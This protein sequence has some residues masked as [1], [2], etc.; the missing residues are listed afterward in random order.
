[1][2]RLPWPRRRGAFTLLELLVV[3]A[4]IGLLMGLMM[5]AV[6]KAR[7]AASRISCANNL[8]QIAIAMTHYEFDHGSLPPRT[9]SDN[10]GASWAVLIM[11]YMEQEPVYRRWDL[12]RPYYL[13]N[14]VARQSAVP[15][16][17]CPSRRSASSGDLSV[18]GDQAW[19]RGG[20]GP[21]V[22]GALGDYAGC[23]GSDPFG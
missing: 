22:P 11:P 19:L 2:S 12:S 14:D 10:A 8:H 20:Y 4:I 15:N 5:P 23:M 16:F 18:S 17:F 3:I 13:Q 6:Q 21:N 9:I 1:M 7:E